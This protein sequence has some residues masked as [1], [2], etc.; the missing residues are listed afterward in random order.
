MTTKELLTS[1]EVCK[2]YRCSRG[3]LYYFR[4]QKQDPLPHTEPFKGVFLYDPEVTDKWF[5]SHNIKTKMGKD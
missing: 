3:S 1:P 5:K 4:N 2:I